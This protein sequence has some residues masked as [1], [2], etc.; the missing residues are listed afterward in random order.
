MPPASR[1][2]CCQAALLSIWPEDTR[3]ASC[4]RTR[5][6]PLFNSIPSSLKQVG[7]SPLPRVESIFRIR[8]A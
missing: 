1:L 5:L 6:T 8:E 4:V 7:G 2:C 3:A